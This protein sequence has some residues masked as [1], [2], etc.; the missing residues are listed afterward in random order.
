MI[1]RNWVWFRPP[2]P[3]IAIDS[4]D[5]IIRMVVFVRGEIIYRIE[6]GASFCQVNKIIPD[7]KGIPWVTSG[8]Q[9]W[10]GDN[11]SFIA[12][13]IVIIIDAIGLINFITDQWPVYNKLI[14]ADSIKSIE[15]V[16]C[17][18]KYF[19]AASVDRG[20]CCLVN[21]GIIANI[22]IS[23][24]IHTINQWEL[25]ITIMVP[26]NIVIRIREKIIGFISTGRI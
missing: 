16:A 21:R 15:A 7:N 5:I 14:I 23:N 11:P 1:L 12:R 22:F 4:N 10:K 9:K 20:L 25:I 8:T 18:R 17:V 19:V 24:P 3:P 26:E 6:R 13:A 2:H